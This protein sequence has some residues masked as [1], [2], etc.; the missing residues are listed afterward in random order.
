MRSLAISFIVVLVV[1]AC[2]VAPA[3]T[4]TPT[5]TPF[6]DLWKVSWRTW[7]EDGITWLEPKS[8]GRHLES[9]SKARLLLGCRDVLR[10][11]EVRILFDYATPN[12]RVGRATPTYDSNARRRARDASETLDQIHISRRNIGEAGRWMK[13]GWEHYPSTDGYLVLRQTPAQAFIRDLAQVSELAIIITHND[14]RDTGAVFLVG[15]L[16]GA[17][18]GVDW[19][20]QPG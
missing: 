8:G 2:A 17:L 18:A 11:S 9:A 5:A 6:P 20:C 16:R 7:Y 4:P 15:F 3:P 14:A 1:A 10:V 19:K 13:S 12:E